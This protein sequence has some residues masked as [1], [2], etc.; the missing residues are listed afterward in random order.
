MESIRTHQFP[1]L[2]THVPWS[3][4]V[5]VCS[6]IRTHVPSGSKYTNVLNSVY[7]TYR[8][9]QYTQVLYSGIPQAN[10]Y[11]HFL[12]SEHMN[13]DS[14]CRFSTEHTY[15][16]SRRRFSTLNT[17]TTTR[18]QV[19]RLLCFGKPYSSFRLKGYT[20]QEGFFIFEFSYQKSRSYTYINQI[21]TNLFHIQ[22]KQHKDRDTMHQ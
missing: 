10:K 18:F 2:Y 12:Y 7:L 11:T 4:P 5:H 13:Q 15:Q 20:W 9:N 3:Q 21:C 22:E 6:L 17:R 8:V 1:T 16:D 19:F 14:I